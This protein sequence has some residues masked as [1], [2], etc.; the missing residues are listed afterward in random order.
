MVADRLCAL[1]GCP[2]EDGERRD[3]M[4]TGHQQEVLLHKPKSRGSVE[5]RHE[6]LR[7]I[8]G[9]V[10]QHPGYGYRR[11]QVT[12]LEGFGVRVNHKLLKKLLLL[13]SLA[14]TKTDPSARPQCDAPI[15]GLPRATENLLL[16]LQSSLH[17][18]VLVS[19]VTEI[20]SKRHGIPGRPSR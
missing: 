17:M 18:R 8:L 19:G 20:P 12:L 10:E 9:I 16:R 1:D 6:R 3:L 13:W 5:G 14:I 11:I 2:R 7:Q 4:A 15:A